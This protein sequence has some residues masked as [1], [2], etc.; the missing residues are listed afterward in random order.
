MARSGRR[1]PSLELEPLL[2]AVRSR[3]SG[4]ASSLHGE[5]HWQRVAHS[6]VELA[7]SSGGDPLVAFCFGLVH[8]AMREN[9]GYDPGHGSRAAALAR[10]LAG[11]G[12]LPA[13]LLPPLVDACELHADGLV[14][15]D[16]VI[17]A[18]WD[19]DR[20]DL[21][22]VGK[23]VDP[24]LLSTVEA[25]RSERIGGA[26]ALTRAGLEWEPL[27]R[28]AEAAPPRGTA[29]VKSGR[30]LAGAYPETEDVERIAAEAGVTLLVD[31]TEEG[32]LER[33]EAHRHVRFGVRDFTAAPPE[34]ISAA[35]DAID[36][37]LARG[38]TVYIHCWGGCGRTG[39]VVS[40]WL[41]RHGIEPEVALARYAAVAGR[42]CP[43]TQEQRAAVL[44]WRAGD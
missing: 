12:L 9:D 27:L 8:D 5:L 7:W 39:M 26:R 19:A 3:A 24:S 13:G 41:A 15:E 16:P 28:F 25:R 2:A 23:L 40:C 36:G 6:G 32:E 35:L 44:A 37:E 30:L 11:H 31:L 10:E 1:I 17:G 22:R 43:E 42:S 14:T 20:L 33:Y 21:W 29:W 18:C 4:L 38:G 34:V